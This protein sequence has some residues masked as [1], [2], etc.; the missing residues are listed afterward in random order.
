[1]S[2][3]ERTIE[4]SKEVLADCCLENG[5][6][7]AAN[8]TK[9][10][11]PKEAKHYF[12]VWPRDASY[13]C[14]AADLLDLAGVQ[15]G[16]FRWCL[17]RVEGFCE[18]GLFFEKYY[19]NGLK[20]SGRLQPDQ[21]GS[22]L[23]AIEHH[24]RDDLE[25]AREFEDLVKKAADGLA[26]TWNGKSFS[27]VANDLW[28]ERLA[29]PDLAENFTY[30]LAA[31]IRG[32]EA[33]SEM[34]P[35]GEG[36]ENWKDAAEEMRSRLDEH[37]VGGHF[38]RSYGKIIDR[39]IDAS[40]LGLV[41]PFAIREADDPQIVSTVEEI[42]R[43]LVVSDGPLKGGVCRYEHD[44]YDGWMF[45]GMHR[46]K[47]AGVWPLLNFWLSIY[48]S[49]GGDVERARGYYD[50]VLERTVRYIPEQIFDNDLQVSV[51]PLLWSHA[52]FVIASRFLG[53]L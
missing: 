45:E 29:F 8:P 1:M 14:I 3:I 18:S 50:W 44:E 24:Y 31:C 36:C 39:R 12:Y 48:W 43:R 46:R 22:V 28:E 52:N 51:S 20:A 6:I 11:Y 25:G 30:T 19:V 16:F 41:Y 4:A 42:E 13:A 47:G 33:A 32:L 27:L 53:Y 9:E 35:D 38:V 17:R 2:R 34:I 10:Y 21:T 49:V 15:E 23:F 5:A 26:S 7:V 37:F 40:V